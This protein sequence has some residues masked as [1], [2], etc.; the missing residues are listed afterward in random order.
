MTAP[1]R[2]LAAHQA[3][4]ARLA[5]IMLL[6]LLS[7]G[8]LRAADASITI[9][10]DA[11]QP[12]GTLRDL[13]GVN[14]APVFES[15][16]PGLNYDASSLY[17]AFGISQARLHDSG[18]DLCSIYK[19]A[20][21]LNVGV[22]PA[23]P[24]VGCT[25]SG[26]GGIPHFK[27]TPTSSADAD[28]NNPDNYD[29]STLDDA[30]AKTLASGAKVY[31][32]LA[33]N[34]NGPNDTDDPVAWAKVATNIY[35]HVIGAFKP[36]AGIAVDPVF[37]EIHNEPDGGFW[38]GSTATFNTLYIENTQRV[39]A[40]A[41]AAGKSVKVGGAGFTRDVLNKS[42]EAGNPANGFIA[43]VGA[44]SLDFYSA[45]L[46]DKCANASLQSSATY[47]RS[48]RAM[49]DS[50]GGSGKPLQISEWNIGLGTQCGESLYSEQRLQSFSA[51]LLTLMQDPAQAIN[52]AHFYAGVTVMSV[53]D[54]TSVANAVRVN[55]SAWAFWAHSKLA[56]STGLS[57]Q[58]CAGSAAC[59]AGYAA[60]SAAL[61]ALSGQASGQ[62]SSRIATVISND[63]SS[64]QS[65]TLKFKGLSGSVASA[66]LR[67]PPQGA[68]SVAT[69]ATSS[70]A[71]SPIGAEA[72][73]LAGLFASVSTEQRSSLAI[74]AG[75]AE[76]SLSIPARSVQLVELW[77]GAALPPVSNAQA[78]CLLNWGE[79]SYPTLLS[80][81]KPTSRSAAPF[82]YR[83]YA[84]TNVYL[85]IS[86]A[87]Q[88]LYYLPASQTSVPQDLGP[89]MTWVIQAKCV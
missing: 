19:P 83:Y 69:A 20:T 35:R 59:I 8:S 28:L 45:H 50:Q 67:N 7:A 21:K 25:L 14:K 81:A 22:T 12:Q 23:V 63:S 54:F 5:A 89:A 87:D 33:Q 75:Q 10:V 38:R 62:S 41:A 40:A 37:V 6:T 46:Y 86:S 44:S 79:A 9:Q 42:K 13:L 68:Q 61:Q 34:Y 64:A 78:D 31:L 51:G 56:G 18:A 70:A 39:R 74:N 82:Y 30:L 3:P 65:Y 49:V 73:A 27:W 4:V 77:P 36:T 26:T 11:S 57:T 43:A 16:T 76:L 17:R 32:G 53:F 47:L 80:P 24:V 60:D 71:G 2:K 84:A 1:T 58:V 66:L 88:H 15:R 52:A 85:G 55:P 72:N 48:L 29:F